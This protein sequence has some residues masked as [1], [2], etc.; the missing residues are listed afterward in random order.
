MSD[1]AAASAAMGVPE[2]LVKRSAEAR[3]K[4]TGASVDEILAAWAGGAGRA[5]PQRPR[6]RRRPGAPDARRQPRTGAGA[7][8]NQQTSELEPQRQQSEPQPR[9]PRPRPSPRH[10]RRPRFLRRRRSGFRSSSPCRP[11]GSPNASSRPCR[12]GWHRCCCS[13]RCSAFSS[14][15]GPL[16]MTAVEGANSCRP[17]HRHPHQLRRLAFRGPGYA[18]RQHR[19]HRSWRTGL[20]RSSGRGRQLPGLSR[21][22]GPGGY[23]TRPDNGPCHVL[24]LRRP[25]RMGDQRDPGL[26]ERRAIHLRRPEQTGR[27]RRQHAWLW[28]HADPGADR[29]RRRLRTGPVWRSCRRRGARRLR[30]WRKR[31]ARGGGTSEE[32]P[33][34]RSAGGGSA[35]AAKARSR[36]GRHPGAPDSSNSWEMNCSQVFNRVGRC[37]LRRE[38]G[39]GLRACH[40]EGTFK[41]RCDM[42]PSPPH[43]RSNRHSLIDEAPL[44]RGLRRVWRA[45]GAT[46]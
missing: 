5:L 26:P 41:P 10:R 19:L 39:Y 15:P 29:R 14:S 42:P 38:S 6:R 4:A 31:G 2:A 40:T 22:P 28:G 46:G 20:H 23:G 35:E 33:P 36:S 11:R 45:R 37:N 25:H 13:S 12:N 18:G 7:G 34:R 1:L 44:P 24:K 9:P 32:A 27:R 43:K 16:R 17:G 30:L 3:A 21:R 8:P